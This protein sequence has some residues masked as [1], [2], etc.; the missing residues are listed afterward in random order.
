M[1]LRCLRWCLAT[2]IFLSDLLR[3]RYTSGAFPL[4]RIIRN[5]SRPRP[6]ASVSRRA[7]RSDS[8]TLT[9]S[10]Q[11]IPLEIDPEP[12]QFEDGDVIVRLSERFEDFLI[13]HSSVLSAASD[14]FKRPLRNSW[15]DKNASQLGHPNKEAAA[16]MPSQECLRPQ[17]NGRIYQIHPPGCFRAIP[18]SSKPC[19]GASGSFSRHVLACCHVSRQEQDL[20]ESL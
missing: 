2:Y 15:W 19:K 12:L 17:Q 3:P 14:R 16:L 11:G 10:R 9:T 6:A 7:A 13:L 8:S 4:K 1:A 18:C 5:G 20:G